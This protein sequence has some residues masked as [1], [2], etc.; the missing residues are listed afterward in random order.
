MM[1]L[2]L[3]AY[4]FLFVMIGLAGIVLAI[5][6]AIDVYNEPRTIRKRRKRSRR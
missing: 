1:E 4:A 2:N 5:C 3:D 6:F